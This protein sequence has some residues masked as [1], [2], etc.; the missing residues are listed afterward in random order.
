[1]ETVKIR[2]IKN[3]A[4]SVGDRGPGYPEQVADVPRA[5]ARTLCAQGRAVP[6]VEQPGEVK[7]ADPTPE[8]RD[9]EPSSDRPKK[10]TR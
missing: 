10:G 3:V 2:C 7:N 5:E 8:N 6:L 9:P 4:T 1:M